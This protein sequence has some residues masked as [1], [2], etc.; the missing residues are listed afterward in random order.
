M[1]IRSEFRLKSPTGLLDT[2]DQSTIILFMQLIKPSTSK[3]SYNSLA[4]KL[5]IT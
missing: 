5:D 2:N 1:K 4:L 3:V